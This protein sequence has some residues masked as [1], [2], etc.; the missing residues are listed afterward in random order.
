LEHQET[1][2]LDRSLT[3]SSLHNAKKFLIIYRS[4][5]EFLFLLMKKSTQMEKALNLG[6]LIGS[7]Y[8]IKNFRQF[9]AKHKS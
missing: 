4:I 9:N 8:L 7:I 3:H 1:F 2:S 5:L 6:G